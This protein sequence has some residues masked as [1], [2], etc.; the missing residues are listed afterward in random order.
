MKGI[1]KQR[2][3]IRDADKKSLTFNFQRPLPLLLKIHQTWRR[4]SPGMLRRVIS[5]KLAEVSGVCFHHQGD[6]AKFQK[7]VIFILTVVRT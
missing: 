1:T 3:D 4:L 6:G 7:T 5:W 2:R